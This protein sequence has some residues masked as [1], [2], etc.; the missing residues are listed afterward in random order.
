MYGGW[1]T[2]TTHLKLLGDS[3][4]GICDLIPSSLGIQCRNAQNRIIYSK[5]LWKGSAIPCQATS[6]YSFFKDP[7]VI[8][9]KVTVLSG[10]YA[11]V[12]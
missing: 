4:E 3:S 12:E 6:E 1:M 10:D 2:G 8:T 7:D 5:I 11:E 9:T